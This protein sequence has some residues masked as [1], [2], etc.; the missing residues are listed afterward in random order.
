MLPLAEVLVA[1]REP[2]Q[3]DGALGDWQA[4]TIKFSGDV[5]PRDRADAFKGAMFAAYPGDLVFSKIDARNGAVG[6]I[7]DSISKAIVTSEYPVFTPKAGKL[8]ATYLHHLLR[9]DHFKADLQRKASGTSGRKRVT[10]EGFLSL[11]VPV[12]TLDEQDALIA[13]YTAA[14][15]RAAQLEQEAN[16]IERAGWKAFE[17][18]LG[19]APPPPLP[20]RPVFVARFKEVERWSHEG[21]LRRTSNATI[22]DDETTNRTTL[23][24]VIA[25]LRVGWSPKC[26]DRQAIAGEWGVLKLS[27][28]TGGRFDSTANK[29]LPPKLRPLPELEVRSGDVL[30]TRGSGVTRLVGAAVFV[31]EA[32]G[33]L[34][35]C[36]LIFRVVFLN[37]SPILP[38]FLAVVLG[39]AYVRKQIE[40]R[41][42]GDAP[43]M[44]K[45]TKTALMGLS[46]PLPDIDIQKDLVAGLISARRHAE[47]KRTEAA[48]L[49]QSA[50]ATFETA[51]FNTTE[52]P[53]S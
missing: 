45:I 1:R 36:D 40:E 24:S 31:E 30:I 27:A 48:T 26:L 18:A 44:Q 20:N 50:W 15:A 35:I 10:P 38:H 46:I 8:R 42:T 22:P 34:M 6:L 28:V 7:P 52:E 23:G 37:E 41:R 32:R 11:D 5:L 43:M 12:P 49:R 51:L 21:V 47:Y 29:A 14:L 25:D 39:T 17:A 3:V 33:Q 53:T 19:V 2:V 9:A 4:I 13:T 16:A